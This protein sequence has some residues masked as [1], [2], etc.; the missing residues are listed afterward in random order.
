MTAVADTTTNTWTLVSAVTGRGATSPDAVAMRAIDQVLTGQALGTAC[1][2]EHALELCFTN[3]V[4]GAQT[5]LFAQTDGVVTVGLALGATVL[6]GSIRT[7]FEVLRCL[8][9]ERN[10]QR[11]GQA[12][13]ASGA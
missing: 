5:L 6:T 10:T 8:R 4:L 9:R 12:G 2:L 13:L 11:A 3:A 7:L 1:L